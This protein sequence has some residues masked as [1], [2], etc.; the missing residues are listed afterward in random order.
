MNMN[1]AY[2]LR[3]QPRL[4]LITRDGDE[5]LGQIRKVISQPVLVD[6]RADVEC[7][8]NELARVGDSS[9]PKTLDLIGHASPDRSLLVLGDWLIDGTRSKVSSFFRGLDDCEVLQRIGIT[10]IRLL[11]CETGVS[12]AGR[13]TLLALSEILKVETYGTTQTVGPSSYDENG[14]LDSH[15]ST[16][17]SA[18]E[19]RQRP[20]LAFVKRGGEPYPR[21]LDIECLPASPLGLRP[22]YPRCM[23]D[24]ASARAILALIRRT[25]GAQMPDSMLT[26]MLEIALPSTKPNWYHRLQLIM[27]G[28]FVRVFPDGEDRPGVVFSVTDARTLLELARRLADA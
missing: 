25:N 18:T 23:A 5:V 22:A 21:T 10:A 16:L 7:V 24:Y 27:D 12:E 26:P 15:T 4:S 11:G 13:H 9:I 6:G 17:V 28:E 3:R 20:L 2:L 1:S 19:I 8:L 14:F